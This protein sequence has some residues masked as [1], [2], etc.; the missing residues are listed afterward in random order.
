MTEIEASEKDVVAAAAR[1]DARLRSSRC[2]AGDRA[3]FRVWESESREN[4]ETFAH[5]Q[6][7]LDIA[8]TLGDDARIRALREEALARYG[9]ARV[10]RRIAGWTAAASLMALVAI[11]A[12]QARE[13]LAA[14]AKLADAAGHAAPRYE[15][16]RPA[17]AVEEPVGS[18]RSY[19]TY[20]NERTEARLEDG[21]TIILNANTRIVA[22]FTASRRDI[23]MVAGQAFFRVRKDRIR[24]FVVR[25]GDRE[26]VA[27]G[28]AF[29]VRLEKRILDVTLLEG[30]VVV[31]PLGIGS[32]EPEI[33]LEPN[34]RLI[35]E[36]AAA[37]VVK[38][39][40]SGIET[41]WAEGRLYFDDTPLADAVA[42]M[43]RYSMVKVELGDPS[44]ARYRVSGM[45]RMGSQASF[46]DALQ[47]YFPVIPLRKSDNLFVLVPAATAAPVSPAKK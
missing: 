26:V 13:P 5:L 34:Q 29:E 35:I 40:H 27:V 46:I 3:A 4:A 20:A 10:R 37:P 15:E 36:G 31:K 33:M 30:Q 1:W 42:Q 16:A 47:E 12:F 39:V 38:P 25:A 7:A 2:T 41:G 14:P 43:N 21:S 45:F 9:R 22:R 8:R 17:G 6:A 18:P 32:A 28:T 44:L 11:V 19:Q 24:P 23:E